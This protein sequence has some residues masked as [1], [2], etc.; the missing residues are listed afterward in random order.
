M[1]TYNTSPF[2][3][4]FDESKNFHQIL[5][6]PGFAVQ[7]RELTQLQT[8]LRNQIEK[9]GNHV[10]KHG[11]VVIPG[12]SYAELDVPFVRIEKQ[13]NGAAINPTVFNGQTVIGTSGIR[14][15]VKRV[16]DDVDSIILYVGY[17]N[18]TSTGQIQFGA[19]EELYVSSISSVRAVTTPTNTSGVGSI[20]FVNSGIYYVNGTFAYVAPQSVVI[21]KDTS[22]PSCHV[23]LK[24]TETI[25]DANDDTTL[26]DPS[27]GSYNYAAPGADR[28]KIDLTLETQPL[29]TPI[30]NDYVE[31]MRYDNGVLLEHS[32]TPKYS[33]LEKSLARRTF[34]ES[35]NYVVSGLQPV[36]R[37]HKKTA[38]NG[39]VYFDG[40]D[41]KLVLDVSPGK[42]YIYGYEVEK[43]SNT[44]IAIDKART[45][46]HIKSTDSSIRP[47]YGQYFYIT[48]IIGSFGI[49]IHQRV[50]LWN[51]SSTVGSVKIG[52]A[53]VMGIDY[54]IGDPQTNAIY[55]LWVSDVNVDVGYDLTQCGSIRTAS[56][57][58]TVATLLTVPI[59]SGGFNN[60]EI[61]S[62]T[63][64]RSGTVK[65][66]SPVTSRLYLSKHT[67]TNDV[68]Q[69]G[70]LITGSVTNTSGSVK[71]RRIIE[72][73]GQSSLIFRLTKPVV[74]SLRDP[75]TGTYNIT[76]MTQKEF[77]IVT[78]GNGD[79]SVGAGSGEIIN[80][81][82]IGTFVA[83][84]PSGP[85]STALFSLNNDGSTLTLIGGPPSASIKV[86]ASV[87]KTNVSP[88]TKTLTR[89]TETISNPGNVI[90]LSKSD[91]VSIESVIDAVGDKTPNYML[92]TGQND[93]QYELGSIH[94]MSGK[95]A[96]V[97]DIQVTYNYY[98][99]SIFG[100]FF[101]K[102]SYPADI[103][104]SDNVFTS[105]SGQ[106]YDLSHCIDFRPTVGLDNTLSGVAA[107]TNDKIISGT[108]F[109]TALQF[110][111]GRVDILTIDSGGALN[112]LRG[113]PSESPVGKL[114]SADTLALNLI[115]VP[116]Y[117]KTVKLVSNTRLDVERFTMNDIKKMHNRI[118]NVEYYATLS[119]SELSVTNVDVIDAATGLSRF[120]TGYLVESFIG[121]L[122]LARTT[123]PDYRATFVG[124]YLYPAME[125]LECPLTI[126]SNPNTVIVD[127]YLTLP[128]T[129]ETFASQTLSSRVTNIN[130]FLV[131]SWDGIASVTPNSD[132]WTEVRDL[133][134]IF[135]ART[136]TNTVTVYQPCPPPPPQPIIRYD[137]LYGTT[138]NRE[139][140]Q[141]GVEYWVNRYKETSDEQVIKEFAHIA[142]EN[143]NKGIESSINTSKGAL[144]AVTTGLNSSGVAGYWDTN[145]MG[146]TWLSAKTV[147][148]GNTTTSTGIKLNGE[149]FTYTWTEA[150]LKRAGY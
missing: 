70:D 5:F 108:V 60:G 90:Q 61:V 110:Y 103:L 21:S 63:S 68:P 6:K 66:W 38:N 87:T 26:L 81:V 142:L 14:A 111:V 97:G 126:V 52:T 135:D 44:K 64:G 114:A 35:G 15:T 25:V 27:Q 116:P 59:N 98:E 148:V 136:E 86:Y 119:T 8:I 13:Y 132:T 96:P 143:Y 24:I 139:G 102:D 67:A 17:L 117:T 85:V 144:A 37:E 34:D 88:K 104:D 150:D 145:N 123:H 51:S 120:K 113:I 94:L 55:K 118:S 42:G 101:C 69:V 112:V 29:N 19:S 65:Y 149:T 58:A 115:Y 30:L 12:N 18:G 28:V 84:G 122:A 138:L 7:A 76:Y 11:S 72:S 36:V 77:T 131:V 33:E 22:T 56:S 100:D 89:V 91:V 73:G 62:H 121:P 141:E 71:N 40:D 147:T 45:A 49:K 43:L 53:R 95:S 46:D 128:Y 3:D 31:I 20:A 74:Y 1:K 99:H 109:K 129:E 47:E 133:P 146:N 41:D 125:H 79:G 39:G 124:N 137:G 32:R 10:F 57:S 107:K 78:D 92:V 83:L 105:T 93:Y 50:D 23:L 48:D 2:F 134:T 80:P 106:I 82:E 9:F 75:A 127:G 4:D 16:V 54:D 130:P 140:E